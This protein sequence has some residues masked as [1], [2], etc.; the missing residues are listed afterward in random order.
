MRETGKHTDNISLFNEI[1]AAPPLK[2]KLQHVYG[3]QD[4]LRCPLAVLKIINYRVDTTATNL[5]KT[6]P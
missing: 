2:P 4:N 6:H 3:S 5:T 1:W